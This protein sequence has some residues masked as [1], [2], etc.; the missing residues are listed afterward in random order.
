MCI[1]MY[2]CTHTYTHTNIHTH[3]HTCA[4]TYMCK[5]ENK[6]KDYLQCINIERNDNS[7]NS[8]NNNGNRRIR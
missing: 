3:I 6:I 7:N 5:T 1:Y 4:Y 8:N 2:T